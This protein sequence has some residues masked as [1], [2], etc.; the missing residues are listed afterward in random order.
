[1]SENDPI[2][3]VRILRA[4]A[5]AGALASVATYLIVALSRIGYPFELEWMEGGSVDHVRRILMGRPLYV[6][7]SLEF[8]PYIYTPLY[9]Y[10][11]AAVAK[12]LGAGFLALRL[13]SL[14][15]SIGCFGLIAVIVRRETNCWPPALLSIGLFAATFHRAGAWFDLARVDSLFLFLLLGGIAVIRSPR[16]AHSSAWAGVL[17]ALSF[18]AKQA[19]LPVLAAVTVHALLTDRRRAIA[20]ILCGWGVILGSTLLLDRLHHGWYIYYI[21]DLPRHHPILP[22]MIPGFWLKDLAAPL[23]AA[24]ALAAAWFL[25]RA[26]PSGRVRLFFGLMGSG[27]IGTAWFSRLHEGG[28]ENVLMPAHAFTAILLGLAVHRFASGARDAAAV[29]RA[30]LVYAACIL[31]FAL[32]WYNPWKEIPTKRDAAAGERMIENLARV[33][34]DLFLPAHGYLPHLAGKETHAHLMAI[35]DVMRGTRGE[36]RERLVGEILGALG[37][38]RFGA[39][40]LDAA[41]FGEDSSDREWQKILRRDYAPPRNMFEDRDVFWT[42]TGIR[43]RPELLFVLSRAGDR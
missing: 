30:S 39:V 36:I 20:L 17:F 27:M 43:T 28:Y 15:S 8:V 1:M 12:G 29:R 23:P 4:L 42:V 3:P 41:S 5:L 31:Q 24:V 7:P 33:K 34:G 35:R 25:W 9:Y 16:T 26:A 14:V 37:G 40:V 32:L 13:V 21:L 2:R 22:N 11:S 18:L 10:L 38:G 6:A 19:A